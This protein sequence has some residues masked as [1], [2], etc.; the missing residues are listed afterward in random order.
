MTTRLPLRCAQFLPAALLLALPSASASAA[1]TPRATFPV[2]EKQI[3]A[4]QVATVAVNKKVHD[5]HV[6]LTNGK[7]EIVVYPSHQEPQLVAQL[8]AAGATVKV[9]KKKKKVKAAGHHLRY[10]AAGILVA[11]VAIGGAVYVVG[12]RRQLEAGPAG[13][14]PP[15]PEALRLRLR[16]RATNRPPPPPAPEPPAAARRVGSEPPAAQP[17]RRP[18][19]TAGRRRRPARSRRGRRPT[20]PSRDQAAGHGREVAAA[21]TGQ[22]GQGVRHV[23]GQSRQQPAPLGGALRPHAPQA[24]ATSRAPNKRAR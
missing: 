13:A 5:V 1:P 8:T 18:A 11:I 2:L 9:K 4:H 24:R 15:Q 16:P 21:A 10:I 6:T 14:A 7:H 12:R 22:A 3:A 23:A 20:G 19:Q 17:T